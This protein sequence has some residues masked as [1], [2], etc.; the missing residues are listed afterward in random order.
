MHYQYDIIFSDPLW[1][2]MICVVPSTGRS[3]DEPAAA[4]RS[5]AR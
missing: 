2:L 1:L 3:G 5:A 4:R